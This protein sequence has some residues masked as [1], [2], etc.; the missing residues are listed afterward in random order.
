[1]IQLQVD[2]KRLI[3][4]RAALEEEEK[5]KSTDKEKSEG[6]E[7][8]AMVALEESSRTIKLPTQIDYLYTPF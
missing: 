8:L 2:I 7:D 1:M 6:A 3:D 4:I 5:K